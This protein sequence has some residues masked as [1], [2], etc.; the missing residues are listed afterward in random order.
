MA[1]YSAVPTRAGSASG[2]GGGMFGLLGAAGPAW[3]DSWNTAMQTAN[4]WY[5]L[6]NRVALDQYSVPMQAATYD[7]QFQQQAAGATLND[8]KKDVIQWLAQ[9]EQQ[10]LSDQV[11]QALGI[12]G[13]QYYPQQQTMVTPQQQQLQYAQTQPLGTAPAGPLTTQHNINQRIGNQPQ[14]FN[15]AFIPLGTQGY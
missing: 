13:G 10:A 15:P 12:P 4:N 1:S 11:L 5:N 6:Q 3:N 7:N 8:A 2:F 9:T 14:G